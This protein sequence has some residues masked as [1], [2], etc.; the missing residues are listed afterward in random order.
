MKKRMWREETVMFFSVVKWFLLATFV[1]IIVGF[2]TF[3]FL[4]GLGYGIHAARNISWYVLLL[5]FAMMFSVFLVKK[6]A[7]NAEGHGTEKVIE[8]VH[9]FSGRIPI[10]V[11][12]VK[13][14]ATIITIAFGGSAGKEGPSAQ[15]GAGLASAFSDLFR[16]SD[17]AR[18]KLVICGISAGFAAVF[19]TPVAGALFGI[20]VL[21][22]GR[23]MYDVLFPSFI[24][25]ITAYQVTHALG[26]GYFYKPLHFSPVFSEMFFLRVILAGIF[27]GIVSFIFIETMKLF[28]KGIEAVPGTL[29]V[30]AF[31]AGTIMALFGYFVTTN[32]LGLG[33]E[34]IESMI[35]GTHAAWYDPILKTVFT[36]LTL[37]AGGSGGVITPIF[38]LGASSGN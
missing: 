34:H 2:S 32:H 20:E 6:F 24:A 5:P 14:I 23:L 1:G 33:I 15:I 19:G 38:Y 17:H 31:I 9:R 4:K 36:S 13:L 29:Y 35:S 10:A 3:I 28:K 25:G 11:V 16:F 21:V 27:F 18:K 22:V 12:P 7:P 37:N 26:I 8:A 30:K